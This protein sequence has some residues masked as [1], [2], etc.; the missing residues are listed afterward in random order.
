[1]VIQIHG[2]VDYYSVP[3]NGIMLVLY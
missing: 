3:R 1:M 2:L